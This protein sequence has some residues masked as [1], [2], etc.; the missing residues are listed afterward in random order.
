MFLLAFIFFSSSEG[1]SLAG[2]FGP[3]SASSP[4]LPTSKVKFVAS[5]TLV[6]KEDLYPLVGSVRGPGA[7]FVCSES[8]DDNL[9]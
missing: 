4:S 6:V 1:L 5:L 2:F 7:A 3:S 8:I 9:Q